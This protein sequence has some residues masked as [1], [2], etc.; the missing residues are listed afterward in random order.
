MNILYNIPNLC[1]I[2]GFHYTY[3]LHICIL[4]I[5]QSSALDTVN[6]ETLIIFL[7]VGL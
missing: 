6:E 1:A 3:K 2:E 7:V 4:A 5:T